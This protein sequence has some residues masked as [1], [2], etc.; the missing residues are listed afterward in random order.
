MAVSVTDAAYTEQVY[1]NIC[2]EI[3]KAINEGDTDRAKAMADRAAI[4][5]P[6]A[7]PKIDPP[8]E[9]TTCQSS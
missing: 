7:I 3:S 5:R 4:G 8:T 1:M 9:E 2:N 6:K